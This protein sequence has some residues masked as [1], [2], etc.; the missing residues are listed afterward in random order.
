MVISLSGNAYLWLVEPR[1][2]CKTSSILAFFL[3]CYFASADP[4][5]T[6]ITTVY[7]TKDD[8]LSP[9]SPKSTLVNQLLVSN[10]MQNN[11]LATM[12]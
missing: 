6:T 12:H 9:K 11:F 3:F 1:L 4:G 7:L 2:S 8:L 10:K 5:S